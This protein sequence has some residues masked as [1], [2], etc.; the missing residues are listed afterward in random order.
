MTCNVRHSAYILILT[1]FSKQRG[2]L[3]MLPAIR[4]FF[5]CYLPFINLLGFLSMWRDKRSAMR[6]TWRT[7][8]AILF[9]I[10]FLG[11]SVGS[12]LGMQ[13]FRH[14]TRHAAFRFGIPLI[15]FLQI[16]AFTA[17]FL[18]K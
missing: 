12:Y 10:A 8:E 6:G 16:A 5:L 17:V 9:L 14:K 3:L 2:G 13:V 15:F 1:G 4:L 11:G 7:P 18:W